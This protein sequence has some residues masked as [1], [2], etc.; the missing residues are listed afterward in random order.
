M[1]SKTLQKLDLFI[2]N[3]FIAKWEVGPRNREKTRCSFCWTPRW[4]W[5]WSLTWCS[6]SVG[7]VS[8]HVVSC[9][10]RPLCQRMHADWFCRPAATG[11]LSS[12]ASDRRQHGIWMF[13]PHEIQPWWFLYPPYSRSAWRNGLQP[14]EVLRTGR[15][16]LR[17]SWRPVKSS[18]SQEV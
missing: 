1:Q 9:M 3:Q 16:K 2:A 12:C 14:P 10:I 8:A 17:K 18:T 15:L 11:L 6:R 4:F 13:G 7:T 5:Y